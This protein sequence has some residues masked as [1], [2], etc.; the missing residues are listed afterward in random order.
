MFLFRL[1]CD[2][3]EMH[4]ALI[5]E[6]FE[7]Y[8]NLKKNW[9]KKYPNLIGFVNID[10][11]NKLN[12]YHKEAWQEHNIKLITLKKNVINNILS[13]SANYPDEKFSKHIFIREYTKSP[14]S[15][16]QNISQVLLD[17]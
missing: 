9:N 2:T 15:L 12:E 1:F 16:E 11:Y 3:Q 8:K 13:Y 5:R 14:Y 7:D 10:V 6:S 17:L 4:K